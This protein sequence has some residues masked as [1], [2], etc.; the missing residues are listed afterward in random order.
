MNACEKELQLQNDNN[1]LTS[2]IIKHK[3]YCRFYNQTFQFYLFKFVVWERMDDDRMNF[4]SFL[5]IKWI[6]QALS[7]LYLTFIVYLCLSDDTITWEHP[8]P[9]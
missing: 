2:K 1:L 3:N 5:Q 4:T 9:C 7:Q 8:C 6:G